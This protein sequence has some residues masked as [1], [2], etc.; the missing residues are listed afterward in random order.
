MAIAPMASG[1]MKRTLTRS[2][3]NPAGT[4]LRQAPMET[5][6]TK[7]PTWAEESLRS[8]I[9]KVARIPRLEKFRKLMT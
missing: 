3:T 4:W 6:E 7:R 8:S 1:K 9:K 2:V 5:A